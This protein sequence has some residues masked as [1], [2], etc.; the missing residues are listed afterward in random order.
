M[1][2]MRSQDG[3]AS[4]WRARG[5]GVQALLSAPRWA[6]PRAASTALLG[7]AVVLA[8][9]CGSGTTPTAPTGGSAPGSASPSAQSNAPAG[10]GRP[11]ATD[12][13]KVA[14]ASD[15]AMY[16]PFFIAQEKGYFA[17]EGIELEM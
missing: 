3:A 17:D 6:S 9:A 12:K 13:V 4:G 15:S 2:Q 10:Q 8:T 7:A 11:A 1:R 5:P 14:M 16:T